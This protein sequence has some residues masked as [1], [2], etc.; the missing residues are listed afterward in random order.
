MGTLDF[1]ILSPYPQLAREAFEGPRP[2]LKFQ[3]PVSR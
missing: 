1:L 3:S 2:A